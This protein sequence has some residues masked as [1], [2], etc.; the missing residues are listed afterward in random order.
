MRGRLH[1]R[2]VG[3]SDLA[4]LGDL[5]RL[6]AV[7][8]GH[9]E[10]TAARLALVADHA[11]DTDRTVEHGTQQRRI[12]VGGELHAQPPL[13]ERGDRGQLGAPDLEGLQVFERLLLQPEQHAGQRL[14][15]ADRV[16][17]AGIG[18]H[19]VDIL[20]EHHVGVDLVQV[21]DQRAVPRGTEQQRAVLL[22]EG[23]VVG[24]HGDGVGRGLLHREG[25][26]VA[27]SETFL[28]EG[29]TLREQ[30]LESGHVLGRDG[31]V[32]AHPT[33]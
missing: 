33:A 27:D 11:A 20:D 25:D 21:L 3:W 4:R 14:L 15:P 19:V 24:I 2:L 30:L 28:V 23:G 13:D 6:R 12:V 9:P 26:V 1:E 29:D 22:P 17:P 32:D 5:Q 8:I 18:G 7:G 10:G 16:A 31:E